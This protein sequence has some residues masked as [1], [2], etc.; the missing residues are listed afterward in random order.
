MHVPA[1]TTRVVGPQ[2][3]VD[4][5]QMTSN[6]QGQNG[7]SHSGIQEIMYSPCQNGKIICSAGGHAMDL[8]VPNNFMQ[9]KAVYR[10]TV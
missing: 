8:I 10:Y 4:A 1:S 7:T 9:N 2:T 6:W 5:H 3:K